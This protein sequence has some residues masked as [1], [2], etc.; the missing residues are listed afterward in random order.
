MKCTNCGKERSKTTP[1]CGKWGYQF[2]SI[3][4]EEK[5]YEKLNLKKYF[6]YYKKFG[7]LRKGD[8]LKFTFFTAFLYLLL[9]V[10]LIFFNIYLPRIIK[11]YKSDNAAFS[12]VG[13]NQF[14]ENWNAEAALNH[15]GITNGIKLGNKKKMFMKATRKDIDLE[16]GTEVILIREGRDL[17][18][19][20]YKSESL[21]I[22]QIEKLLTE[23][24]GIL[25]A[26][27]SQDQIMAAVDEFNH[28]CEGKRIT[29]IEG[30]KLEFSPARDKDSVAF[31]TTCSYIYRNGMMDSENITGLDFGITMEDNFNQYNE[32]YS[33]AKTKNNNRYYKS[34]ADDEEYIDVAITIVSNHLKSPSSADYVDAK[35]KEKDAYGRA[36]VFL[37]VDAQNS[38]GAMIRTHFCI[39][40]RGIN[41][42]G[43]GD[44]RESTAIMTYDQGQENNVAEYLKKQNNF[45]EPDENSSES[46]SAKDFTVTEHSTYSVYD[47]GFYQI[48]VDKVT[49]RIFYI[50]LTVQKQYLDT[51]D[52]DKAKLSRELNAIIFSAA[53][54]D[55]TSQ[56][57]NKQ[58]ELYDTYNQTVREPFYEEGVL[59]SA[60]E[61]GDSVKFS[62]MAVDKTIC[63]ENNFN[64]QAILK[65]L[66]DS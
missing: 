24:I 29:G 25:P 21:E 55:T 56:M 3:P 2:D 14:V 45:G 57:E 49:G 15:T 32:L 41:S 46:L 43:T 8:K 47:R 37:S 19:F 48:F 12:Q 44:Y 5:T 54:N 7:N 60:I 62:M 34:F 28:S 22:N 36:V 4:N 35:V 38:F 64:T 20:E 11:D 39:V 61:S 10:T 63:E 59:Y 1:F 51:E 33:E 26:E 18:L 31:T 16:N 40:I 50:E 30:F 13:I 65:L 66:S 17:S 23:L 52:Y 42:D 27:I 58:L 53:T 6:S 9:F